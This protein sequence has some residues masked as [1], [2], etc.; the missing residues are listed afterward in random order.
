MLLEFLVEWA[1]PH[2]E[3]T[4][5]L[6]ASLRCKVRQGSNRLGQVL[7]TWA[8]KQTLPVYP[9][10]IML[11]P[12]HDCIL[13]ALTSY[14]CHS[15]SQPL[16]LFQQDWKIFWNDVTSLTGPGGILLGGLGCYDKF[17]FE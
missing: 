11:V 9:V 13:Q 6:V 8:F 5:R 17:P 12:V 16:I 1:K 3:L 4:E 14:T 15:C 10:S 7:P 2:F